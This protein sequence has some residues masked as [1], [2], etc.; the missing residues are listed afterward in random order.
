MLDWNCKVI[1]PY[2]DVMCTSV[3]HSLLR[4]EDEQGI[5]TNFTF[6]SIQYKRT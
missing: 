6:I 2:L 1:V 3:T 4:M 5:I